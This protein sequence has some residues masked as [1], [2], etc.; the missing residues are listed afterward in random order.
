MEAV[1]AAVELLHG[2]EAEWGMGELPLDGDGAEAAEH[3]RRA[4]QAA[5]LGHVLV[6]PGVPGLGVRGGEGGSA[7]DWQ[8]TGSI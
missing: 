8:W 2:A 6:P 7:S 1:L 3:H 4:G 5:V